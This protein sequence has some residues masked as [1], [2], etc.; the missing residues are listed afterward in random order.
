M[1]SY[2]IERKEMYSEILFLE[3]IT[4]DISQ[5]MKEEIKA[6]LAE[7]DIRYLAVNLEKVEFMDSSG[8]GLLISLF[9]EVTEKKGKIVFYGLGEYVVKL[10]NLVKLDSIFTIVSSEAEA[11][12]AL[13]A[14]E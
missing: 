1:S 4:L 12:K 9:K 13:T 5:I 8:L 10:V 11:K 6:I 3:D 2:T 7:E 14:H